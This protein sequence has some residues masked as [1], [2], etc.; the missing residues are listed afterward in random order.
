MLK[1]SLK[2]F[3]PLCRQLEG[4][5]F[6]LLVVAFCLTLV[7]LYFW[8]QAKNDYNDFDWWV[9]YFAFYSVIT[10]HINIHSHINFPGQK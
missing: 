4:V 3:C 9:E 5:S 1:C 6:A 8:G 7:F 2:H 10:A